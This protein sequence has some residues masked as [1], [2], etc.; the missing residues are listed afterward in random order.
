[1]SPPV[2]VTG[3][4][5]NVGGELV[6]TLL[7]AG[8]VSVVATTYRRSWRRAA[9]QMRTAVQSTWRSAMIPELSAGNR[10]P[11]LEL[12]DHSG[13]PRRLRELA[14]GDP[15]VLNFYRGYW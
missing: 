12:S 14:G 13:N 5:G 1:M 9:E 10:F 2:L 15:L 3:A 11:D 8:A 4:A 7:A 6:R